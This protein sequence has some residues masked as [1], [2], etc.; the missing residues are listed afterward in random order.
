[1]RIRLTELGWKGLLLLLALVVA[2]QAT[3]YHNLFFLLL[4]F[5]GATAVMGAHGAFFAT[6]G[7]RLVSPQAPIGPADETLRVAVQVECANGIAALAV[8]VQIEHAGPRQ[9]LQTLPTLMAGAPITLS[10][11]GL[12]RGVH[13]CRLWLVSRYPLGLIEVA[14]PASEALEVVIHPNPRIAATGKAAAGEEGGEM[15]PA[16]AGR[17]GLQVAGLRPFVRG[18]SLAAVH[19]KATARRGSPVVKEREEEPVA[20]RDL[21]L[22]R[23]GAPAA[24]ELRLATVTGQLLLATANQ[25]HV[26]LR[27]SDFDSGWIPPGKLPHATLRYLAEVQPMDPEAAHA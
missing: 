13:A 14:R 5:A 15:S 10:L 18:D 2:F 12:P 27:S 20:R 25:E 22:D 3:A 7:V 16:G 19:W 8:E 1:M 21:W 24:F 4:A 11:P 6:R 9:T 17:H 26:R 23:S